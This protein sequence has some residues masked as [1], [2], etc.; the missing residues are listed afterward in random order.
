MSLG[1]LFSSLKT[2]SENSEG[3]YLNLIIPS[4]KMNFHLVNY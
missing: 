1:L 2:G 4:A 3:M